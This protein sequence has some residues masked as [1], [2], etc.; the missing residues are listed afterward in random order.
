MPHLHILRDE[1][2]YKRHKI[3]P[4]TSILAKRWVHQNFVH[5]H[6]YK[7][8]C[9]CQKGHSI[10]EARPEEIPQKNHTQDLEP[11]VD[12][13]KV[14]LIFS[15]KLDI[16]PRLVASNHDLEQMVWQFYRYPCLA[17]MAQ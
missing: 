6:L 11:V 2:L 17:R 10:T 5:G 15:V 8:L 14:L 1:V 13:L 16:I 3:S 12:L 7:A 9:R 4:L